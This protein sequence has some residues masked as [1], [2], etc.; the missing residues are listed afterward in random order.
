M[1]NTK[2]G[3]QRLKGGLEPG[4][5]LSHKTGTG[6]V[7]GGVQAGY[8]DIGIITAPDGKSYAMAVLIR[9]TAAPLGERMS[10]MQRTVRAVISYHQALG[11]YGVASYTYGAGGGRRK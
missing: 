8:N 7:L 1:A 2:T 11:G 5:Q 10:A 3:A 4:W 9:R 6:Q